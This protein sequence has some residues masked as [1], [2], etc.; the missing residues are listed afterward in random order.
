[1]LRRLLVVLD[2]FWHLVSGRGRPTFKL[3]IY[4]RNGRW[5]AVVLEHFLMTYADSEEDLL[6]RTRE[7]LLTHIVASVENGVE[8]FVRLPPAPPKYWE[9]YNAADDQQREPAAPP[10]GIFEAPFPNLVLR[11]QAAA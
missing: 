3:L 1:M 7:M 8:P 11:A 6:R 5:H 9:M 4:S 2:R 10:P